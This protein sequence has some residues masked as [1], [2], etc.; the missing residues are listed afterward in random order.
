MD[1]I[2]LTRD[3]PGRAGRHLIVMGST[4]TCWMIGRFHVHINIYVYK[5]AVYL[6]NSLAYGLADVTKERDLILHALPLLAFFI[7]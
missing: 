6:A 7:E 4:S 1:T 3:D 2:C 5:I